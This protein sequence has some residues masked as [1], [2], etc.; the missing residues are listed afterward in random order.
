M[1]TPSSTKRS[2]RRITTM[3]A[4]AAAP[5]ILVGC[6][7][8]SGPQ[9]AGDIDSIRWDPSPA[10]HTLD[11]RSSDRMNMHTRMKDSNLRMLSRDIDMMWF[12]DRPS[13]LYRGIKP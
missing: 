8:T 12:V 2:S 6:S 7:S 10:M 11:Q 13:R 5:L 1:N 3:I 9:H 4:L